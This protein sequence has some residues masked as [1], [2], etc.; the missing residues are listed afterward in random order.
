MIGLITEILIESW[1]YAYSVLGWILLG[2]LLGGIVQEFV[3]KEWIVKHVGGRDLKSIAKA[4]LLG[5]T[6]DVC[7][8][9][10]LPL[11]IA[12]FSAGASRAATIA[13]LIATPWIGLMESLILYSF[14]GL[15]LTLVI[16]ALSILI[17]FLVGIF[18]SKLERSKRIES[19]KGRKSILQDY[20]CHPAE[21]HKHDSL[22]NKV[23][24]SLHY[25][26]D[27]AR[28]IGKWFLIGF[29]GAGVVKVLVPSEAIHSYL[30]YAF[31][32]IPLSLALT[33]LIEICSEGS[34]P[35]IGALYRLGAS[36]GVIFTMLLGGVAT[37]V[38][39]I[40]TIWTAFG[41]RTALFTLLA[42]VI[43]T[44]LFAYL[45]NLF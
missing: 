20:C 1:S 12:L 37:D 38:T 32:S 27:L 33:S 15:E 41:K 43:L 42:L 7:S 31:Y 36:P 5:I 16:S 23:L 3:P 44:L 2:L 26:L 34:V 6:C 22:R 11:A 39:E 35:I 18:I 14:V 25:S 4:S 10:V 9:G 40:G 45:I 21:H 28:M 19:W 24:S 30:G 17:A 29:I 8:H 13:F